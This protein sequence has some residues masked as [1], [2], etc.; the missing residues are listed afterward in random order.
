M[1]EVICEIL[2]TSDLQ[3][4]VQLNRESSGF[5]VFLAVVACLLVPAFFIIEVIKRRNS[6]PSLW[7]AALKTFQPTANWCPKDPALR[8]EYHQFI[9]QGQSSLHG[10]DNPL[11]T[12]ASAV[13]MTTLPN[14][15]SQ[16][17]IT[18]YNTGV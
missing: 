6:A 4:T 12:V 17:N 11:P 16:A 8:Q 18:Q 10:I 2:D 14:S 1:H 15:P 9:S 7:Q 5:G 3:P 13:S